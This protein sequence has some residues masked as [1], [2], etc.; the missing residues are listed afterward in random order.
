[1]KN[2]LVIIGLVTL[3]SEL[4]FAASS[5]SS[6]SSDLSESYQKFCIDHTS[7]VPFYQPVAGCDTF[8]S[9]DALYFFARE[10]GFY[11]AIE[12]T[13]LPV[14]EITFQT[15]TLNDTFLFL[16]QKGKSFDTHWSPGVRVEIGWGSQENSW[17]LRA[18][19]T[20]FH[21]QKRNSVSTPSFDVDITFTD[22]FATFPGPFQ[23]AIFNP[24]LNQV[25]FEA[26]GTLNGFVSTVKAN[27]KLTLND[28]TLAIGRTFQLRNR[29]TFRPYIGVRGAWTKTQ[30]ET[31]SLYQLN[32]S[33]GVNFNNTNL[34]AK[35]HFIDHFWGV[36]TCLGIEPTW[37]FCSNWSIFGNFDAAL[38][39]GKS[40]SK[41]RENYRYSSL[42]S[43]DFF[44]HPNVAQDY[45]QPAFESSFF[46][47]QLIVDLALGLRFEQS[48][49]CE[50]YHSEIDLAWE[51]HL[52]PENNYRIIG[53]EPG[54]ITTGD[55]TLPG[56]A[57]MGAPNA[58]GKV[59]T[60][61]QYG[62]PILR[63]RFDF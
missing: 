30:L 44:Q 39:Y 38:I 26:F 63:L 3:L 34:V 4:A 61:L 59:S 1:M 50:R 33:S 5:K 27:W 28:I 49:C 14:G 10:L 45:N 58:Y 16:D 42:S 15:G 8:V 36:G 31:K 18:G 13:M 35:D 54:S 12:G 6:S 62:G 51:Y 29:F 43:S 21:N 57:V 60:T 20:Y 52:W 11:Y 2:S 40:R 55:T 17:D 53:E 24:W 7:Y 56:T 19:W 48:W 22:N 46:S 23:S 9:V 32:M 25:D 41:K 47:M 37:F